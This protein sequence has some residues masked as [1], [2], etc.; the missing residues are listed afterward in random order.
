MRKPSTIEYLY[1]DFDGFFA[2]VEQQA[3]PHLRRKPVGIVPFDNTEFTCVIACSKEAKARGCSNV[4]RVADAKAKCP[5][6]I[7][8]PQ[9]PD[10]YRRAHN[11][12]IAEI[13]AVIPVE[14]VKSIDELTCRLDD[15]QRHEPEKLAQAIKERIA[16]HV[17]KFITCSIGFGSNRHLAKIAGKQ[18]KPDGVTIWHPE[19]LPHVLY[20]IP[21]EDIPGIG[22]RLE[23]RLYGFQ[24]YNMEKLLN[25]PPKH[26]RKIWRN[27]TGERLW[28]ALHGY[29]IT[30]NK[31]DRGH[32]GHGRVISPEDR[33]RDNVKPIARILVIKAAR[34]MRKAGYYASRLHM[35]CNYREG[36]EDRAFGDATT[37]PVVQDDKACLDGLNVIWDRLCAFLSSRTKIVRIGFTLGDITRAGTRQLDFL[38]NDDIERRKWERINHSIDHL[39]RKYSKSL[40]TLGEYKL[41][42]GGNLGGKI[43]YTRIPRAEDFW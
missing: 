27:V 42:A 11:T 25:L 7:L 31:T 29:A 17:G 9:T 3:R 22:S 23:R 19:D 34:R 15:K 41:P 32:F 5:D 28:Y 39:N 14:A 37:L 38:I 43:S 10:L 4:M 1:L 16:K 24:I 8:Q 35:W 6:I 13:S 36:Y 12:L 20:N 2:S 40:V 21:F 18:N 26:M 33:L 30:A